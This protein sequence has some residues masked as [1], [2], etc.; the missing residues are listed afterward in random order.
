MA[1]QNSAQRHGRDGDEGSAG[2]HRQQL[3]QAHVPSYSPGGLPTRQ[4]EEHQ[5]AE[6]TQLQ[7]RRK[8]LSP[9][10]KNSITQSLQKPQRQMI[11]KLVM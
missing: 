10:H 3:R 1:R 9:A 5:D 2:P 11:Q 4:P 6:R 8:G 7:G